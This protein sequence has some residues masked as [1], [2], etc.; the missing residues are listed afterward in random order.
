ML[1]YVIMQR[2]TPQL[3]PVELC[4]PG[5]TKFEDEFEVRLGEREVDWRVGD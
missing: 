1:A 2:L 5:K 4:L 3:T